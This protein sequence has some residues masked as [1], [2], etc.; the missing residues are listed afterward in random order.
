MRYQ[1]LKLSKYEEM[2]KFY[3]EEL[4][5]LLEKHALNKIVK[6]T[7]REKPEWYGQEHLELK[8]LARNYKQLYRSVDKKEPALCNILREINRNILRAYKSR[9]NSSKFKHINDK[10]RKCGQDSKKLFNLVSSL[11]RNIKHDIISEKNVKI[12]PI[13]SWIFVLNKINKIRTNLDTHPLHDSPQR[14]LQ[15]ELDTFIEMAQEVK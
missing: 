6:I 9:L 3:F 4:S 10:V 2:Y 14:D 13:N 5:N 7:I 11:T 12:Y 8:R 15:C 1:S